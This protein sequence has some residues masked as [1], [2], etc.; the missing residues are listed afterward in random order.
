MGYMGPTWGTYGSY[1]V[2]GATWGMYG[3]YGVRGPTW[4][5]W[6]ALV[7]MGPYGAWRAPWVGW[8][9][10]ARRL[11]ASCPAPGFPHVCFSI[12]WLLSLRLR[13]PGASSGER[14]SS[15]PR[16][17]LSPRASDIGGQGLGS[18]CPAERL[19]SPLPGP[20]ASAHFLPRALTSLCS[21]HPQETEK[22]IAELNETWEEKLRRTEAIRMERWAARAGPAQPGASDRPGPLAWS[23][24]PRVSCG[25]DP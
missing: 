12:C 18:Q 10:A 11:W 7:Y 13:P 6:G 22:I 16:R 1:G 2:Q 3:S 8:E 19:V 24:P 20:R 21:V 23:P 25:L 5:T 15:D 17:P 9:E 4:G 14:C